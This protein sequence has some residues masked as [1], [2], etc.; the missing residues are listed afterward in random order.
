LRL[1][2]QFLA[3]FAMN[4]AVVDFHRSTLETSAQLPEGVSTYEAI[5]G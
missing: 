4:I 2:F 1:M 5:S 3:Y